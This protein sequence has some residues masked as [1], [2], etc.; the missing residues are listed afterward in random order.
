MK[1]IYIIIIS[2]LSGVTCWSQTGN[3]KDFS[4][5]DFLSSGY[6]EN[7]EITENGMLRLQA[8]DA[9]SSFSAEKKSTIM[10]LILSKGYTLASVA[11]EYKRELWQKNTTS[12]TVA[13]IDSWDLN[14]LYTPKTTS[15]KTL[16]K[17]DVHPWFFSFS[18]GGS[19]NNEELLGLNLMS[20]IGFFLLEDRWNLALNGSLNA[21]NS[22]AM[23][24]IGLSSKVY[25][26]IKK[27][28]ISPYI[29]AGISYVSSSTNTDTDSYS[30]STLDTPAYVGVS[31][32]VGPGSLDFGFTIGKSTFFMVGYTFSPDKLLKKK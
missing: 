8:K 29:G 7:A 17:S 22:A 3:G 18:L 5:E 21:D 20:G 31:W 25:F 32:F 30:S 6:F 27:Y 9:W 13:L 10:E 1:K 23:A 11:Y 4:K 2:L 19:F 16:Q 26:P 15:L 12:G 14:I 24:Q 28:N